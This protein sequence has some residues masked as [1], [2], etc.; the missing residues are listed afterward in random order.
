MSK[1]LTWLHLSDIHFNSKTEWRD[2]AARESLLEYLI[3]LFRADDSLRPDL[4]FCTGDIAFGQ[5]SSLPLA[6]QYG[7]AAE[8]FDLLLAA[9][10]R[11]DSPLPR[12]RLFVVPGNHD[13]NR[14]SIN[15][16]AQDA[17]V[18]RAAESHAHAQTINQRFED[19]SVEFMDA[20]KRL[21]EYGHFVAAYLP[22]QADAAGRHFYAR[23]VEAGGLKVGVAGF[24]SAWSCAGDEDDRALWLAAEWQFNAAQSQLKG[25]DV[26]IGLVHHPIDWLNANE[27]DTATRRIPNGF[28]FW[29]HGH[30]HNAWVAPG[31]TH[32][33]IAAGAVGAEANEEF[34]V[35]FV[36]LDLDAGQS[37]AELHTYSHRGGGWTIHPISKLAPNGRWEFPLPGGLRA[38]RQPSPAPTAPPPEQAPAPPPEQPTTPLPAKRTPKLFGRGALIE[39]AAAKLRRQPFLLV[40]GLR[41]N[42]KTSLIEVLAGLAPL[43]EKGNS[44]RF[45]VNPDTTDIDLFRQLATPLGETAENP[46]PPAGDPAAIA[47]AL[48]RRYPNPRPAWVWLEHAHHL[49]DEKGHLRPEVRNLLLGLQQVL[50]ARWLWVLELRERPAQLLLGADA[51]ECEVPGLDRDSLAECLADAAPAGREAD[52]HYSGGQLKGI[53]Q[54]LGGGHGGRAHPLATQLLIEVARG[55]DETP[56]QALQRHRGDF[57][58]K[59][60]ERL[61]GDLY[62]NVL[63]APEQRLIQALALYRTW[64]PH[65]HMHTLEGRLATPGAWDGLDRRCLISA[66]ADHSRYHLHSFI[67]G[68][69][70]TRLGYAGHGEDAE[71]D[72]AAA[73]SEQVKQQAR[74]LH[75]AIAACWLDDLKG[76]R[77]ITNFNVSRALEAFH[78]LV[79]AGETARVS[80]IAVELLTGNLRWAIIRIERLY[81]HLHKSGAPIRQ[82]RQALEY[83]AILDPGNPKVHRF[84]GES[85]AKEEGWNSRRALKCFEE[86]CRLSPDFSHNWANLGRALL[87]HGGEG[88]RDFLQRLEE[89]EQHRPEVINDHVRSIQSNCLELTGRPGDASALRLRRI[90][91]GS[92]NPALYNDEA[93]ARLDAGD[94]RAALEIL[95]LAEWNGCADDATGRLK[96]KVLRKYEERQAG[97]S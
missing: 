21:D 90:G 50:G 1:K 48:R 30:I 34:G 55:H 45:A 63:S 18:H 38:S 13:V 74:D 11:G 95:D 52:W 32:V 49:L 89:L 43:S 26:R 62:D 20:I 64:I 41:G 76:K 71:A 22:H 33:T 16:D 4:I 84:L 94:P 29:L 28:H 66:D 7:Q 82:L 37:A 83:A 40:Y 92:R 60:E 88:A 70:R 14:S 6:A 44:V 93:K 72:F 47:A 9:C 80:D 65:D 24:N 35:N 73:A 68:W 5:T 67:A 15:R 81:E 75:S 57:E 8:F 10:G 85:W 56:W 36:R 97:A 79:A 2:S 42:G 61:L 17:L 12:G 78:H 86:A 91:G 53:Y 77:R 69:L 58:Q 31:A 54:W 51:A 23:V 39:E 19:R 25:S 27:R 3:D 59:I 87:A 46:R 96:A